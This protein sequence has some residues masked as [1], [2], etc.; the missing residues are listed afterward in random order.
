MTDVKGKRIGLDSAANNLSIN[1]RMS[2]ELWGSGAAK[3]ARQAE[4]EEYLKSDHW[5]DLRE[6][7]FAIYGHKCLLCEETKIDGHHL[8]Y[9]GLK[10]V[11]PQEVIPL[12]RRH[13]DMVHEH[14][15]SGKWGPKYRHKSPKEKRKIIVKTF[16]P[17]PPSP[18]KPAQPRPAEKK[19]LSKKQR[20]RIRN[21][22]K[23]DK[24]LLSQRRSWPSLQGGRK[25]CLS[26]VDKFIASKAP[27]SA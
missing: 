2:K 6:K 25:E 1:L 13:H 3:A 24:K 4:Y 14:E 19:Q 5:R 10:N 16:N 22:K 21:G 20:K 27:H 11:Q 23:W 9:R 26:W 7:S 15:D 18:C 12:C 17:P 8:V